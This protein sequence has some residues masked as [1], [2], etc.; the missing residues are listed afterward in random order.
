MAIVKIQHRRGAYTDYDPSKLLP[1]EMAVVQSGDP[2][3]TDG[4]AVYI[5]TAAGNVKRLATAEELQ[6]EIE[7]A[8]QEAIPE[9]V[10]EATQEAKDAADRAETAASTFVIDKT[11]SVGDRPADAKVVGD[12]ITD[13]KNDLTQAVTNLEQEIADIEPGLSN[14]AKAALLACFRNVV[15]TDEHGQTYYDDLE[16]ALAGDKT[17]SYISATFNPGQNTI[18]VDDTLESLKQYLV[19]TAYYNDSTSAVIYNYT[20][21]GTLV[22]GQ[23]TITILY[24]NKT[25]T[26][27]VT[28]ES[29]EYIISDLTTFYWGWGYI[30]KNDGKYYNVGNHT[31][32][33]ADI[34]SIGLKAGDTIS[35]PDYS[36]YSWT[37]TGVEK[38]DSS[39]DF[40]VQDRT[41]D[42]TLTANDANIAAV[43]VIQKVENVDITS[44][45][46]VYV[47]GN[48]KVTKG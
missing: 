34:R 46:K 20:L 7:T 13:V 4:K 35:I 21:T 19:V 40:I 36:K 15:W 33:S 3:S 18:Y 23:N 10:A 38:P 5:A 43:I 45:E 37:L 24:N 9:F 14:A 42:Y 22:V 17:L 26:F 11:L 1:G 31:Q 47:E 8:L 12:K 48:A 32:M 41:Q 44:Q 39:L 29:R 2:N 16:A 25:T 28:A 27:V 30:S 6:S